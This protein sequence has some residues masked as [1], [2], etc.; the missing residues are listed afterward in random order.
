M[1]LY[2]EKIFTKPEKHLAHNQYSKPPKLQYIIT[3]CT[4]T[5]ILQQS[6]LPIQ[7]RTMIFRISRNIRQIANINSGG[8][9]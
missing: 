5:I 2:W 3:Y 8:C 9:L 6:H 1:K 7:N 4:I